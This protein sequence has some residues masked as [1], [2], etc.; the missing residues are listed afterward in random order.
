MPKATL[1]HPH[2][3]GRTLRIVTWNCQMALRKKLAA[4][5]SLRPDIAVVQECERPDKLGE[6]GATTVCWHGDNPHKGL[7]ILTFGGWRAEALPQH[8]PEVKFVLPVRISGP[9]DFHLLGVWAKNHPSKER[10]Y[11]GQVHR[12]V[13]V[14]GAWL[15]AGE[16][17][18]AGDWNSNAQWDSKRSA[19]HSATVAHL[20]A[21][22]LESAYHAHHNEA[23][24][25]ESRPT[26]HLLKQVR[27]PFHID[28]CFVPQ[29][30]LRRVRAVTV[31]CFADWR[32]LSDHCPLVGEVAL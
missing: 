24:G 19:N 9:L 1:T 22:G 8:D 18:V 7:A 10:S 12:A 26:L 11:I 3:D 2:T 14:Y 6:T 31:G 27:R 4:L 15:G 23:H 17:V 25:A 13:Q 30:W 20:A 29:G 21:L 16:S 5:A 32:S 28:Y